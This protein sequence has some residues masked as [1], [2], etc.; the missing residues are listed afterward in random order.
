MA[1]SVGEAPLAVDMKVVWVPFCL[2]TT[3]EPSASGWKPKGWS[4]ESMLITSVHASCPSEGCATY[5]AA[6]SAPSPE[7]PRSWKHHLS[8]VSAIRSLSVSD[9]TKVYRSRVREPKARL[10]REKP[11]EDAAPL[12]GLLPLPEPSSRP[13][14]LRAL[15]AW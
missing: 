13:L 14:A 1:A 5:S 7:T 9:H 6:C 3:F 2:T 12:T 11:S 8:R 4:A 10:S 15:G